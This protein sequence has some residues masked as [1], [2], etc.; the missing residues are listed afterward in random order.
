VAKA[1]QK[2]YDNPNCLLIWLNVLIVNRGTEFLGECRDLLLSYGVKIQYANS[3][4]NVA[5][6]EHDH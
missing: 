1:F 4:C 2:I 5:I 3:K 6:A